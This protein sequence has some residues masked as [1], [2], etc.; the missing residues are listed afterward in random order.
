MVFTL[1]LAPLLEFK[2]PTNHAPSISLVFNSM[3]L[4][5]TEFHLICLL[6]SV[7]KA[8]NKMKY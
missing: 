6:K 7:D 1:T 5:Y 8:E 4:L 2:L 3:L